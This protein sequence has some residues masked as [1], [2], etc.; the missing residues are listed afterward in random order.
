MLRQ[1]NFNM[2]YIESEDD[3]MFDL[4]QIK[5]VFFSLSVS[6]FNL[7]QPTHQNQIILILKFISKLSIA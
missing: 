5:Q 1:I 4:N 7:D 6:R 3:F 2:K